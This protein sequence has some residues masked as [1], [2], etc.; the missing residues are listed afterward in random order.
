MLNKFSR[1]GGM[2]WKTDREQIVKVIYNYFFK[3]QHASLASNSEEA[4][5]LL[6][7]Q[8]IFR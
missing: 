5:E 4:K 3:N 2:K 8:C 1:F 7:V 6:G